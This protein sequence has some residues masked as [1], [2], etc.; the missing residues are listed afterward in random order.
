MLLNQHIPHLIDARLRTIPEW[1][2]LIWINVQNITNYYLISEQSFWKLNEDFPNV[3]PPWPNFVTNYHHPGRW[4]S[5]GRWI[6]N[7][8]DVCDILTL[9]HAIP[10]PEDHP[11]ARWILYFQIFHISRMAAEMRVLLPIAADGTCPG[12]LGREYEKLL[13]DTLD[14]FP[15]ENYRFN[16]QQREMHAPWIIFGWMLDNQFNRVPNQTLVTHMGASR[17]TQFID[18]LQHDAP[19][20]LHPTL[21]A[22]SFCHCRNIEVEENQPQRAE[23]RRQNKTGTP[24]LRWH[25][26]KIDPMR[27]ILDPIRAEKGGSLQSALHICRGHF[28]HFKDK[29]LFGKH[30]GVWWWNMHARG[31]PEHGIVK[32]TYAVEAPNISTKK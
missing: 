8:K 12:L 1:N 22:M 24:S 16:P 9:C 3:A 32:K 2:D 23:R 20:R 14:C 7:P 6:D 5:D 15:D 18:A 19:I 13:P 31:S 26:V 4:R 29:G 30:Q 17:A 25:N 27:K 21:L 10:L 11:T 28:K